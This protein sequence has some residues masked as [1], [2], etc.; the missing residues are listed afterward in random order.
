MSLCF[1]AQDR[2]KHG[3]DFDRVFRQGRKRWGRFV[4]L[5]YIIS[6]EDRTRIGLTVSKKVDK[7]AVRRNLVKRR[8]R[9]IFR[10]N[11]QIFPDCFDIVIRALPGCADAQYG[12]L[13]D[14]VLQLA[15]SARPAQTDNPDDK[16][17]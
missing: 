14:E 13:Q 6:A 12:E 10:N 2:L 16:T 4:C 17:V 15:K 7:R 8:L 1:T 3:R 9:E 5:H 11:R